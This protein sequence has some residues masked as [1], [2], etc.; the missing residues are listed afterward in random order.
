[1]SVSVPVAVY[2]LWIVT[3][4]EVKAELK[5]GW[6]VELN[7]GKLSGRLEESRAVGSWHLLVGVTILDTVVMGLVVN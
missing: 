2:I 4:A 5:S 6:A 7:W 3:N 1:M